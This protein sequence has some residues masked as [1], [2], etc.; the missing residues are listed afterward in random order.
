MFLIFY[1]Q[2]SYMFHNENVTVWTPQLI[3][4]CHATIRTVAAYFDREFSIL[5]SSCIY[6]FECFRMP[7]IMRGPKSHD[8][9]HHVIQDIVAHGNPAGYDVSDMILKKVL[10]KLHLVF[11]G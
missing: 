3:Q 4:E 10:T 6:L 7:D 5:K 11:S 2:L 8:I 1:S 9:E